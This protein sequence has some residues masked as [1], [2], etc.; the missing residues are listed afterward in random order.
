LQEGLGLLIRG[1]T[2]ALALLMFPEVVAV[3]APLVG[4]VLALLLAVVELD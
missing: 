3:L 4:L 1:A 2:E